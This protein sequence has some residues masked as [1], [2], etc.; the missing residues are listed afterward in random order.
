VATLSLS[1]AFPMAVGVL[2][3]SVGLVLSATFSV[4]FLVFS[5]SASVEAETVLLLYKQKLNR[6]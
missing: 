5:L 6:S 2:V 4:W 1:V 3:L